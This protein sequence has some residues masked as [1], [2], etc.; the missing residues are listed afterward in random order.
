MEADKWWSTWAPVWDHIEDRHFG[1]KPTGSL[2]D[3]IKPD[4]LVIG[5]GQG[6]IVRYLKGKG[7]RV[8]GLDINP[9]MVK[10]AKEKYNLDIVEGDAGKLPFKDDSYST[11]I[12][13]SGVVDY[14]ADEAAIT[15]FID[16][17]KRVCRRRGNIFVA[18]YKIPGRIEKIY[19]K[20]GVIDSGSMYRMKRI[21]EINEIAEK[22]PPLCA[23]PI[24]KWTGKSMA[25]VNFEWLIVG[26]TQPKEFRTERKWINALFK[27]GREMGLDKKTL[28]DSVPDSLPYRNTGQVKELMERIRAGHKEIKEFDDCTVVVIQK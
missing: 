13:S 26:L 2:I 20:I 14:G 21:F 25:R 5:A 24:Q 17:A 19:R 4:V 12:I 27:T 11:V 10:V 6:L 15:A 8:T 3:R 1:T 16:E 28:T 23:I 18:F 7:I 9:D 22:F